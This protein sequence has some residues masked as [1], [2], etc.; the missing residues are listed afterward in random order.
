MGFPCQSSPWPWLQGP[1]DVGTRWQPVEEEQQAGRGKGAG[2]V[3]VPEEGAAAPISY[4]GSTMELA[5]LS[6]RLT[7]R[8]L[9]T[10][11]TER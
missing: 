8:G 2:P 4:L 5:A 6:L 9:S 7:F 10:A 11:P 1:W 3:V